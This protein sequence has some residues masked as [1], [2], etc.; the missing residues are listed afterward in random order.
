M[1]HF[2][3]CAF[4]AV[5][6]RRCADGWGCTNGTDAGL[7]RTDGADGADGA[8]ASAR[9]SCGA[10]GPPL[11]PWTCSAVDRATLAIRVASDA[12]GMDVD[13]LLRSAHAS[14]EDAI[15]IASIAAYSYAS[16]ALA[17]QQQQR[18]SR[19]EQVH[20][21]PEQQPLRGGAT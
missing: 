17:K 1:S 2:E 14:M 16:L 3:Y 13:A 20:A 7:T 10:A 5:A 11:R 21:S 9:R 8:L 12:D 19:S 6:A 4:R 15:A 18:P